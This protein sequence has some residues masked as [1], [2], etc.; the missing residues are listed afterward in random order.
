[1]PLGWHHSPKKHAD[2]G[3]CFPLASPELPNPKCNLNCRPVL[4]S[5]ITTFT[6][7]MMQTG[8]QLLYFLKCMYLRSKYAKHLH[9]HVANKACC[10]SLLIKDSRTYSG[11]L[12]SNCKESL[13]KLDCL[14]KGAIRISNT[15]SKSRKGGYKKRKDVC[16]LF[17]TG[18]RNMNWRNTNWGRLYRILECV[19]HVNAWSL[20]L[21]WSL[22]TH[23]TCLTRLTVFED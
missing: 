7:K 15:F 20:W 4:P 16:A 18:K 13:K 12:W 3:I 17:T 22:R 19:T 23:Q 11:K 8:G 6:L 21:W 9:L 1:M 2:L 14:K 5:K 10:I